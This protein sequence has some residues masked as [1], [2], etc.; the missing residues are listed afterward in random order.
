[1]KR[2]AR[3]KPAKKLKA[4]AKKVKKLSFDPKKHMEKP[5]EPD[6]PIVR[7]VEIDCYEDLD[8]M[9]QISLQDLHSF[10]KKNGYNP[11]KIILDMGHHIC[12][13]YE[14]KYTTQEYIKMHKKYEKD[15]AI[16]SDW[17]EMQEYLPQ[18]NELNEYYSKHDLKYMKRMLKEKL[19]DISHALG[20]E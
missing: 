6:N 20:E 18:D 19:D 4:G 10:V 3:K 13:L 14:Y 12:E 16:Y 9:E 11:K 5:K 8:W 2:R 1:M 7:N 17:E 15:E